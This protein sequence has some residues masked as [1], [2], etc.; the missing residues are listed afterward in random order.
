MTPH[1]VMRNLYKAIYK[2]FSS[3]AYK[4]NHRYWPYY[5]VVRNPEGDINQVYF[6]THLISDNTLPINKSNSKIVLVATGPSIKNINPNFFNQPNYDFIGVNGAISL[7]INFKHYIIIDHNFINNRFDLVLNVLNSDCIFFTTPRCLDSILRKV[8]FND[9]KCTIKIFETITHDEIEIFMGEKKKVEINHSNFFYQNQ[10]GFSDN[11]FNG[12]F[13]YLTVAYIALQI[14]SSLNYKEIYIA[15]L[16]MNNFSEPRFYENL[17]NKQP[18]IL[19]SHQNTVL[20]AFDT[21]AHFL[22]LKKINVYN[23]SINSAV[24]SFEKMDSNSL[25]QQFK[26]QV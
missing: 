8:K 5:Q 16:D 23:L 6:N 17:Q 26:S 4:H 15:G 13:D 3:K 22:K 1:P 18:T 11:I 21:A 9:I 12:V 14:I 25:Q 7:N 20:E 10:Y 2:I 19:D 24:E